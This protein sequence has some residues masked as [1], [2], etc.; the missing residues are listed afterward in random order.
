[1]AVNEIQ[2][3]DSRTT[4]GMA[5]QYSNRLATFTDNLPYSFFHI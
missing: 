5:N 1:M 4:N 2:T 3:L